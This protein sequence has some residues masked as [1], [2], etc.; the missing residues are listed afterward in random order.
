M[1]AVAALHEA[2]DVIGLLAV[3]PAN[4][5]KAVAAD[6][7]RVMLGSCYEI[8]SCATEY[9][10]FSHLTLSPFHPLP[11]FTAPSLLGLLLYFSPLS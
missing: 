6:S 7:I 4:A 10:G 3:N 1:A 11:L 5:E 8:M 2:V 9:L